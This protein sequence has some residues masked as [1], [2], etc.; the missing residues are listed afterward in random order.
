MGF[1]LMWIVVG[2]LN[3]LPIVLLPIA[4][5]WSLAEV[6]LAVLIAQ[7]IL[8]RPHVGHS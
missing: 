1:A 8:Q 6:A 5:P 7:M 4:V 3:V 2:N